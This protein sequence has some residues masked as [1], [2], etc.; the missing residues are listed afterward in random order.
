MSLNCAPTCGS[1]CDSPQCTNHVFHGS[2]GLRIKR[3][4]AISH[5]RFEAIEGSELVQVA[6]AACGGH[7]VDQDQPMRQVSVA[8]GPEAD[9]KIRFLGRDVEQRDRYLQDQFD[10]RIGV[11]KQLETRHQELTAES[12]R[13]RDP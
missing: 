1:G 13:D 9:L 4:C 5:C 11:A 3:A 10:I 2:S 7:V 8:A 6:R 12:R